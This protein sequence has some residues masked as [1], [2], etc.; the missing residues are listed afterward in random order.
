MI[1]HTEH[2]S[3][4]HQENYK[5]LVERDTRRHRIIAGPVGTSRLA[6]NLERHKSTA[7]GNSVRSW[8]TPVV[9]GGQ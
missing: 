1:G 2:R 6:E 5:P 7:V 3:C 4:E 8:T 9:G